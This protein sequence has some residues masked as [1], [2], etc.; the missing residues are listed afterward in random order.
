M[1]FEHILGVG[2]GWAKGD[3]VRSRVAVCSLQ[4]PFEDDAGCSHV[5]ALVY[6]GCVFLFIHSFTAL[7]PVCFC[8]FCLCLL[9]VVCVQ[10]H[11]SLCTLI[12]VPQTTS[13]RKDCV[14]ACSAV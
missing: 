6:R 3:R 12:S 5:S 14:P 10:G 8:P 4:P 9:V 11:V 1:A 7:L 13:Y 2:G